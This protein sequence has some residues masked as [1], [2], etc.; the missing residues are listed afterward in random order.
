LVASEAS[1]PT[2]A[3]SP[4][5]SPAPAA[6]NFSPIG[7]QTLVAGRSLTIALTSSNSSGSAVR[8]SA[9]TANTSALSVVVYGNQLTVRAAAN[10]V[11]SVE[12]AVTA[13]NGT[14]SAVQSFHVAISSVQPS[15]GQPGGSV[16]I[17]SATLPTAA[18]A[19]VFSSNPFRAV[20][21][22]ASD[23]SRGLH[24]AALDH[25]QE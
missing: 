2:P 7:N 8:Y 15:G 25:T 9:T 14:A 5:P 4:T 11:G 20:M 23:S 21:G 19:V 12:I 13:S 24:P 18:A 3:P 22:P 16:A 6:L 1:T 10:Y 17:P